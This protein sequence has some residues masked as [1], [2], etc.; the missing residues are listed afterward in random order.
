MITKK[1]KKIPYLFSRGGKYT[2]FSSTLIAVI[3][4]QIAHVKGGLN[5]FFF[6]THLQIKVTSV[7]W[8]WGLIPLLHGNCRS[9]RGEYGSPI[10]C[11][12][13]E[14]S[15]LQQ[16]THANTC[17]RLWVIF[18][19]VLPCTLHGTSR[20]QLVPRDNRCMCRSCVPANGQKGTPQDL[21][22]AK[23]VAGS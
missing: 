5:I 7:S 1:K 14:S 11:K 6:F 19:F 22:E 16:K 13:Y 12:R 21:E 9:N 2:D 23:A 15:G 8:I 17:L 10:G 3:I 4:G 18:F 20:I